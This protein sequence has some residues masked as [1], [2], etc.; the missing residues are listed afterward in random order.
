[1]ASLP[2][3]AQRAS[4]PK[5]PRAPDVARAHLR[6]RLAERFMLAPLDD[7]GELCDTKMTRWVDDYNW[8]PD[9]LKCLMEALVCMQVR[10]GMDRRKH[11]LQSDADVKY[12]SLVDK[13]VK[14]PALAKKLCIAGKAKGHVWRRNQ[15]AVASAAKHV[16]PISIDVLGPENKGPSGSNRATQLEKIWAIVLAKHTQFCIDTD[17]AKLATKLAAAKKAANAKAA[18]AAAAGGGGAAAAHPAA[19]PAAAAT[20]G[21]AAAAAA[22]GGAAAAAGQPA[23]AAAAAVPAAAAAGSGA[24]AAA[25]PAPQLSVEITDGTFATG[26]AFDF[27]ASSSSRIFAVWAEFGQLSNVRDVEWCKGADTDC[28]GK[29]REKSGADAAAS[30]LQHEATR[31]KQRVLDLRE[32]ELEAQRRMADHAS[33]HVKIMKDRASLEAGTARIEAAREMVDLLKPPTRC[34][35]TAGSEGE[36]KL[37]CAMDRLVAL[38]AA[39]VSAE[40]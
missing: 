36:K 8:D 20:A 32:G 29:S 12:T 18:A 19:A 23:A 27:K 22:G 5:V 31:K 35:W 25:E 39:R 26:V 15:Y 2:K 38:L 14:D 40:I 1:M 21:A 9:L 33:D 28:A 13:Y 37:A 7:E 34:P 10:E 4:S 6:A 16:N 24:G 17:A 30:D 11:E 3:D